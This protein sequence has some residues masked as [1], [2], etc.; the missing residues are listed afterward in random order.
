MKTMLYMTLILMM[1]A[2]ITHAANLSLD[3][4]KSDLKGGY[5]SF[6][7]S[8]NTQR[9]GGELS[10][11]L[12]RLITVSIGAGQEKMSYVYFYGTTFLNQVM[13][14]EDGTIIGARGPSIYYR[15]SES[16][17]GPYYKIRLSIKL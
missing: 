1:G 9:I 4:E 5:N 16:L 2:G 3:Y 13:M 14:F 10:F 6:F 17:S 8:F 12:S 11:P 7:D 15:K